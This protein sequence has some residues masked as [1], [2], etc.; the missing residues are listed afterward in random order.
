LQLGVYFE[1]KM[2]LTGHRGSIYALAGNQEWLFSA[3]GDGWITRWRADASDQNGE[4][5]G[6]TNTQLFSL[7]LVEEMSLLIAGDMQ[8]HLYWLDVKRKLILSRIAWH[9]GS[10]FHILRVGE[11]LVLTTSADGTICLW[12]IASRQTIQSLQLSAQGLRTS[13]FDGKDTVFTGASDNCL[14]RTNLTA[15][16]ESVFVS[17]AHANS[18]FAI[19]GLSDGRLLTGGRDAHLR[20][21]RREDGQLVSECAAH[22]FTINQICELHGTGLIATAS[23][24]KTIRIWRAE[25]LSLVKTLDV[26]AGGHVNSVNALWWNADTGIL[27]SAGDDRVM[28]LWQHMHI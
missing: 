2:D 3:G 6:Q 14:Y 10:I 25:D 1:K 9:K 17:Q 28:R 27:A 4:L 22:W 20:E 15:W 8:G 23:R 12:D 16:R 7:C 19:C 21:W 26:Q 18:I 5:L 11:G 13:W 24:D